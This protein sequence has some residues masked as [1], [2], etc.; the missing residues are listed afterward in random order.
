MDK[1]F[2]TIVN[3]GLVASWIILAVIVLRKLLNRIPKWVNC[4]LWGLVAIRLAVPFS[5][6]SIFSLIPSAK[7]VPADIEY[8][9]IPKIDSGMHAVN[10]VINPVLENHFAVKEIASVNPIQVIIFITSYIWLI[11]VIGLLIYA[12]VSFIMLKRQVKNAQAVDKGIFR[13][14]T[15]DSPFILGFVKPSIYI[16]DY[17]DN[18]AYIC[19]TEHEKAH[20]KRGDFI[21]KPFGF[22]ILSVYWFNPLC[23]FAYIMLCKDIE[24]ACDEKV[25]KDKDKNWKATYCQVLLDCSSKRKMIAACP[26]AFGE[27]SVKDRIKFVIHYKKPTFWMIVLAFV[28]CIVVGICF[29]TNPKTTEISDD[30]IDAGSDIALEEIAEKESDTTHLTE[31]A[32]SEFGILSGD[33]LL[34]YLASLP[35]EPEALSGEGCFVISNKGNCYGMNIF[36][37]FLNSYDACVPATI[38]IGQYTTEGDLVLCYVAYDG[39]KVTLTRDSRRDKYAGNGNLISTDS[40]QYFSVMDLPGTDG[41]IMIMHNDPEMTPEKV[42][43]IL[44][45]SAMEGKENNGF[46]WVGSYSSRNSDKTE[47]TTEQA[48][49]FAPTDIYSVNQIDVILTNGDTHTVVDKSVLEKVEGMLSGAEEIKEAGCPF[50]TPLYLYREDGTI[51]VIYPATDSCDVFYSD[52]KY[53]DFGTGDN[54]EFW[55]LLG[56]EVDLG[57]VYLQVNQKQDSKNADGTPSRAY[58]EILQEKISADMM[59]GKLPFVVSSS[60]RENPLRLEI[61]LTEM[62]EE[63]IATIHSY[64]TNGSAITLRQSSGI[65]EL[66]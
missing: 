56:L 30:I 34:N 21:W 51:G 28:A 52:G 37:D 16:P 45:S 65:P 31:P 27:V 2:I 58:V 29:L 32:E 47:Q 55:S 22:L 66:Q 48:A 53:Y 4:L 13:S 10:T 39:E 33:E 57:I 41:N 15:I 6:E 19:V 54:T 14:G 49:D 3:N 12:F 23:W 17:L 62:T 46:C 7:P 50:H 5:I 44:A 35:E 63:N 43:R 61:A 59:A 60:I 64:E 1:L 24:Y 42:E 18:E 20:I 40:C 8:A 9:K 25:T 26:V 38:T 11:G 36:S